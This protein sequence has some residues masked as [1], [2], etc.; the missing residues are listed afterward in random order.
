MA[1]LVKPVFNINRGK[2]GVDVSKGKASH[3]GCWLKL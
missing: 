1:Q 3:A 2:I